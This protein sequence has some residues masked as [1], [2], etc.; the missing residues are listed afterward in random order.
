MSAYFPPKNI[1]TSFNPSDFEYQ[2]NNA[3]Y[4]DLRNLENDIL[5]ADVPLGTLTPFI[6]AAYNLP[7]DTVRS[8]MSLP[9]LTGPGTYLIM[10][11]VRWAPATTITAVMANITDVADTL[12]EHIGFKTNYINGTPISFSH[13]SRTVVITSDEQLYIT[14]QTIGGSNTIVNVYGQITQLA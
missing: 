10:A 7:N 1:S 13:V 6:V 14:C 9:L 4:K 3:T 5:N 11:T 8:V 12:Q 2:N